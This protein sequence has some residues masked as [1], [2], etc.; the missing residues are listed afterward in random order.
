M[1]METGNSCALRPTIQIQMSRIMSV[2]AMCWNM[3]LGLNLYL[4]CQWIGKLNADPRV[5]TGSG[6][7]A[8]LALHSRRSILGRRH[9]P[10]RMR[11]TSVRI[12][13]TQVDAGTRCGP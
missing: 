7:D 5:V 3:I 12:I 2:L 10:S 8:I 1:K 13:P 6:Q 11:D 9:L 4:T